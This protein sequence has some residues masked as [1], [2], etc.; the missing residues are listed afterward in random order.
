MY[1][2]RKIDW[3]IRPKKLYWSKTTIAYYT[4]LS[5]FV[6]YQSKL[7]GNINYEKFQASLNR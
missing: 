2:L 1:R 6:Q 5:T 7:T 4:E 3:H